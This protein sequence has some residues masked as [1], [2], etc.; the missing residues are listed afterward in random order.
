KLR[1]FCALSW[2]G[3]G[4][5]LE[6]DFEAAVFRHHPRLARIKRAFL[7]HGA[8]G[9]ALAGSGSAVFG[10]FQTPAQARRAAMQFPDDQVFITETVFRD[11]YRRATRLASLG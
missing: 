8:A 1:S 2:S 3:Q 4:S 7:Q 10:V 6:N 5:H 9:V 11:E